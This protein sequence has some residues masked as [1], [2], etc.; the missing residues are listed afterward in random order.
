MSKA[1]MPVPK[2]FRDGRQY[3]HYWVI[4]DPSFA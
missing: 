3:C 2:A 4:A 1:A